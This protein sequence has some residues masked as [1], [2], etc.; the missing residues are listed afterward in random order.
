MGNLAS[1]WREV[2]GGVAALDLVESSL[3]YRA[4]TRGDAKMWLGREIYD[5]AQLDDIFAVI[6]LESAICVLPITH[7]DVGFC[8]TAAILNPIK[9]L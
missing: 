1:L 4:G 9:S 6:S 7:I 2:G 5:V 8:C 3:M